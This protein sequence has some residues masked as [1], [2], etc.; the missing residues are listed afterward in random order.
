[1]IIIDY[2]SNYKDYHCRHWKHIIETAKFWTWSV[3]EVDSFNHPEVL[4]SLKNCNIQK[5]LN[6]VQ[7]L[8]GIRMYR[9]LG[10]EEIYLLIEEMMFIKDQICL[11]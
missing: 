8:S 11:L 4:E 9:S 2:D 6:F 7:L 3:L 5:R 1:M 10:E